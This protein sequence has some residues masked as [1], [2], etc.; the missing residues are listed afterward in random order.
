VRNDGESRQD[1]EVSLAEFE[2]KNAPAQ[3]EVGL[4]VEGAKSPDRLTAETSHL[5][6]SLDPGRETKVA[7]LVRMVKLMGA[8]GEKKDAAKVHAEP[9]R[10][11]LS[12]H[13][14]NLSAR[15]PDVAADIGMEVAFP[16]E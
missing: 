8:G 1:L 10:S 14:G 16:D 5:R 7:V 12:V 15:T 3:N 9:C 6:F 11:R 2:G 4:V 13:S